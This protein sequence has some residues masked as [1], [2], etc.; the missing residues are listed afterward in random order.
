MNPLKH[1]FI[2]LMVFASL[3]PFLWP[4]TDIVDQ[5]IDASIWAVVAISAALNA[6]TIFYHFIIPPH[7]KFLMIGWR[8]ALLNI[9]IFGGL[10]EFAAGMV[11]LMSGGNEVAGKV[12]AAAAL[13][14]HTPTALA[15]IPLV[16][17]SRAVM[18]PSYLSA[19]IIHAFCASR[20]FLHPLS[21]HW[22]VA[23]FLVF[24]I[25]VWCRIYYYLFERYDLF[26]DSKYSVS[27]LAAGVT[28]LPAVLGPT[29]PLAIAAPIAVYMALYSAFFIR[30]RAEFLEFVR[31]RSRD[32]AFDPLAPNPW[33]ESTD[34]ADLA[35]ARRFFADLD[36]DGDGSLTG[37]DL[38]RGLFSAKSSAEVM[39]RVM[40][41]GDGEE[42]V[43]FP[44]FER[45]FWSIPGV[46]DHARDL[47]SMQ[48]ARSERDKAEMV[49]HRLDRDGDGVLS[50]SEMDA[51]LDKWAP[52]CRGGRPSRTG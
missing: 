41:T 21:T 40:Q 36:R 13:A 30:S 51:L 2:V 5:K 26:P 50:L 34:E 39:K 33:D 31:E 24:N 14:L 42:R 10:T 6:V 25:Y 20:L 52:T 28:A 45:H 23:T 27:I 32:H 47:E 7:P 43:D 48:A 11:F 49:F 9:H 18:R 16:F 4:L 29:A 44:S 37:D 3:L 46:R 22:V 12:M 15:Q 35:S 17:G 8:R 1:V 19:T 38:A